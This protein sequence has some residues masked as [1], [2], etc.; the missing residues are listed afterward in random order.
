[1]STVSGKYHDGKVILDRPVDWA[2]GLPVHVSPTR[3]KI[4]MTED[5]WPTTPEG[6][7][8]MIKRIDALE[9]VELTP[10]EEAEWLAAREEV[11]RYTIQK[12]NE[13]EDLFE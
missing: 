13:Q 1:M 3:E 9:P 12:M 2:E 7:E 10:E 8:A 6:I 4:G 11:K 5:E